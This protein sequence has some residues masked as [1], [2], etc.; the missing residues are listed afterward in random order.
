MATRPT[1]PEASGNLDAAR[2][3]ARASAGRGQYWSGADRA[4]ARRRDRQRAGA[5]RARGDVRPDHPFDMGNLRHARRCCRS[6]AS[7][8]SGR[9]SICA[10]WSPASFASRPLRNGWNAKR[11]NRQ[12]SNEDRQDLR[13]LCPRTGE[14]RRGS[15]G[16]ALLPR[17]ARLGHKAAD[18]SLILRA[19]FGAP[20]Q[21]ADRILL[22]SPGILQS[23]SL[24]LAV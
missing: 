11:A 22:L 21:P 8:P 23:I 14:Q 15:A 17:P 1:A 4:R 10:R 18:N 12:R 2:L 9:R 24:R 7:T 16:R 13:G 19:A 3:M 5:V 20:D 6:R